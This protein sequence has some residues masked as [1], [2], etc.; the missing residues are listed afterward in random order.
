MLKILKNIFLYTIIPKTIS[1]SYGIILKE[2]K[3]SKM[4]KATLEELLLS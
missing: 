1:I 4:L 2:I 3:P